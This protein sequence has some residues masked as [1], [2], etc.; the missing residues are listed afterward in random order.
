[1]TTRAKS[2]DQEQAS[3]AESSGK[4]GADGGA[5]VV[6]DRSAGKHEHTRVAAPNYRIQMH[7]GKDL[8]EGF[9]NRNGKRDGKGRYTWAD[10]TIGLC[11][12]SDG[13]C[14][15]FDEACKKYTKAE[16]QKTKRARAPTLE[17]QK[18]NKKRVALG[19]QNLSA[20]DAR[21][22]RNSHLSATN[23]R[24]RT[25]RN[26]KRN[27]ARKVLKID[28]HASAW[29]AFQ[30]WRGNSI[31]ACASNAEELA[32]NS[33]LNAST[34]RPRTARDAKNKLAKKVLKKQDHHASA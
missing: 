33:L 15:R 11:N 17:R 23:A 24:P 20:T 3:S 21:N 27:I 13:R 9:F 22:L 34:A 8:F 2:A 19:W 7:L 25:A 30:R 26:V 14:D 4:K 29:R 31:G 32:R 18:Y 12:W 5:G 16:Q 1:M 10:G 28:H 6:A